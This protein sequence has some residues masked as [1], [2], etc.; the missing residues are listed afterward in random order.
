MLKLIF[1]IRVSYF[2]CVFLKS[3]LSEIDIINLYYYVVRL[4]DAV[5]VRRHVE[6]NV[7][8]FLLRRYFWGLSLNKML[9]LGLSLK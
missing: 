2:R 5:K 7:K 1:F 3:H 9:F 8:T 6:F 4:I